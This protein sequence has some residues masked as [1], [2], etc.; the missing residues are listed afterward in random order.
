MAN[1]L[2]CTNCD[3]V[4]ES[5]AQGRPRCPNCMRTHGLEAVAQPTSGGPGAAGPSG[6]GTAA[7]GGPA[8]SRI[9]LYVTAAVAAAGII[10]AIGYFTRG[11]GGGGTL[12]LSSDQLR[13]ALAGAGLAP[14]MQ[15]TPFAG[16]TAVRAFANGPITAG[17]DALAVGKNVL[18]LF[19]GLRTSGKLVL[20]SPFRQTLRPPDAA[21]TIAAALPAGPARAVFPY[22]AAALF[23]AA[24]RE[25]KV[26]DAQLAEAYALP[27]RA[28][29]D[30]S[31]LRGYYVV[32]IGGAGGTFYDPL[33]GT[34]G[35][36]STAT[37]RPLTDLQ[38]VAPFLVL[39]AVYQLGAA[40]DPASANRYLEAATKLDPGS[41]TLSA[42]RGATFASGGG[43]KEAIAE[44][45][46]AVAARPDAV[47]HIALAEILL[48]AA[49]SPADLERAKAEI[50][51]ALALDPGLATAHALDATLAIHEG[52]KPRAATSLEKAVAGGLEGPRLAMLKARLAFEGGDADTAMKTLQDEI[53]KGE[54]VDELSVNLI[55]ILVRAGRV[56]DA[57]EVARKL[58]ETSK[59][60]EMLKSLLGELLAATPGAGPGPG[61]GP[62]ML[63]G[64]DMP[65]GGPGLLG[66]GAGAGPLGRPGAGKPSLLGGE[67]L[68][69]DVPMPPG[70]P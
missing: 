14:E 38:A 25:A 9:P 20:A 68:K 46:H 52:D 43:V 32:L 6:A 48:A 37:L 63:G 27:G 18:A 2:R 33:T 56:T 21:E 54:S 34:T 24:V 60:G 23:L 35:A 65:A 22:E 58:V 1:S 17:G 29:P 4:F 3:L 19:D 61:P 57:Q 10:G 30:P 40:A 44:F 47:R 55:E 8:R 62:G 59:H 51:S 28:S 69:L 11:G 7:R 45:E 64:P 50:A 26:A 70:G 31:G 36:A 49:A 67:R 53:A 15:L 12:G 39:Q 16:G 42:A 5:P 41:P 66:D 13:S